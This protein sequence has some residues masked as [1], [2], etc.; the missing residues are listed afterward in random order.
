MESVAE[1]TRR[2]SGLPLL[3]GTALAAVHRPAKLLL[4]TYGAAAGGPVQGALACPCCCCLL[5]LLP[6]A[7]C[8]CCRR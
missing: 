8:C 7:C 6:A 4:P 2:S 5:L 3:M 1:R